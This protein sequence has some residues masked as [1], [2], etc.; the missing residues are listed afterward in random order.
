MGSLEQYEASR[1]GILLRPLSPPHARSRD[2]SGN[3][4]ACS[5][6]ALTDADVERELEWYKCI[7]T[8]DVYV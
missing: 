5:W 3:D 1:G 7:Y 4:D 2:G 6:M 8:C